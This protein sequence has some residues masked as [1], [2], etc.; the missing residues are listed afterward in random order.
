MKKILVLLFATLL[1]G[2]A[3][4]S[5]DPDNESKSGSEDN[6]QASEK[7]DKEN[8]KGETKKIYHIGDTAKITSSTYEFPYEVT[9]NSFEL[10]SD[11]VDGVGLEKFGYTAEEGGKFAVINVTIKNTSTRPFI[12]NDKIS[13]QLVSDSLGM[14]SEDEDFF[15]ERNV[16]LKPG[17]EITGNIVYISSD[18]YEDNVLYMIYEYKAN[19]ETR[20]E[21]PV[22]EK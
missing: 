13:A 21:L 12:P 10:T 18:F 11:K 1:I 3:A 15:K 14:N 20:F 5:D 8:D 19:E 9:A 7:V 4:C 17:E 6:E 16:E 22:P 2:L